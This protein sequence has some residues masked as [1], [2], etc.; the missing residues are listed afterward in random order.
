LSDNQI[1]DI[2]PL[3]SLASLGKL[4]LRDNQISDITILP[5]MNKL[6][7][8]DWSLTKEQKSILEASYKK[9]QT[10][11]QATDTIDTDRAQDA[12][13]CAYKIFGFEAPDIIFRDNHE[14]G[15][16]HLVRFIK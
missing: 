14:Q 2:T 10:V 1:S 12:I 4:N 5:Y 7:N 16:E 8:L 13:K 15:L 11:A 9:W 6:Y 3:R